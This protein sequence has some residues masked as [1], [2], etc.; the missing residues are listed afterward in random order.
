[1]TNSITLSSKNEAIFSSIM[2]AQK[3]LP[4]QEQQEVIKA[5]LGTDKNIVVSAKAGAGKTTLLKLIA[6]A[7][8]ASKKVGLVAFNKSIAT[9]LSSKFSMHRN[10]EVKTCHSLGFS[11]LRSSKIQ[12]T[13]N[14]NKVIQ[15]LDV[16]VKSWE[17]DT[18]EQESASEVKAIRELADKL[19]QSLVIVKDVEKHTKEEL[20]QAIESA[21]KLADKHEIVLS[22]DTINRTFEL[23]TA[24]RR[25]FKQ[26]D[27]TDMIYFPAIAQVD[28]LL[29][30]PK[31]DFILVDEC[32]DLSAAQRVFIQKCLAHGGR[33]IFV[34]DP[35]QA[36]Y[37]FAGAD[38]ESF[39]KLTQ[40]DN[41]VVMPLNECFRCGKEIIKFVN[42]TVEPEIRAFAGNSE[43][44]VRDGSVDE[45]KDSDF[46]MCRST[47]PLVKLCFYLLA[48]NKAAYIKGKDI[49]AGLISIVKKI[50]K[51]S[52]EAFEAWTQQQLDKLFKKLQKNNPQDSEAEI[53]ESEI[54]S[55]AEE[56]FAVLMLIAHNNDF[57]LDCR[58][59]K[60]A[61]ADLFSDENEGICLST[62]HKAK[63]LEAERCFIIEKEKLGGNPK[64]QAWELV[65]EKNIEYV[66]YTRA[67]EELIFISDWTYKENYAVVERSEQVSD[68]I[69]EEM[70]QE[71]ASVERC[72]EKFIGS[73]KSDIKEPMTLTIV[74]KTEFGSQVLYA[75]IDAQGRKVQKLGRINER[76]FISNNKV[77]FYAEV[78]DHKVK[79]DGTHITLINRVALEA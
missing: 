66:A 2:Q 16:L 50:K 34:G 52:L 31:Y 40:I 18:T 28:K 6:E 75:M 60:S 17:L 3:Y 65:Q 45:L 10:L 69:S 27:F 78:I 42:N 5:V 29:K 37:G 24:L 51:I 41:T 67:K 7:I 39:E 14:Q 21:Q 73:I 59:L 76:Y 70:T 15:A 8:P 9:E 23:I 56:R 74:D 48:R 4:N 30:F 77:E 12:I 58:S 38:S 68:N 53:K 11:I 44:I 55:N 64:Q 25:D 57:V 71:S 61:I 35:N 19:R 79:S 1:M 13:L 32:Q 62:I 20:A 46:V 36:I 22:E 49:G 26:V 54:F 43:G 33:L 63:G 47:L 72:S